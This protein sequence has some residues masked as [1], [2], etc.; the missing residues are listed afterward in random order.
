MIHT[1]RVFQI[2]FAI[3]NRR[4]YIVTD[5]VNPLPYLSLDWFSDLGLNVSAF[6]REPDF[7]PRLCGAQ[8]H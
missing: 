5:V 2:F 8:Q 7:P 1:P 6:T 4:V 3:D